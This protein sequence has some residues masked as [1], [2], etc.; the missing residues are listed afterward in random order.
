MPEIEVGDVVVHK[1]PGGSVLTGRIL[2]YVV[3]LSYGGGEKIALSQVTSRPE[4]NWHLG[5]PAAELVVVGHIDGELDRHP[6]SC[7]M[8][9][10]MPKF[11][12]ARA[13]ALKQGFTLHG[14]WTY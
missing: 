12:P 1:E 10:E 9:H 11:E 2:F 13:E 14:A 5:L 3:N 8:S 6:S 7:F 4:L